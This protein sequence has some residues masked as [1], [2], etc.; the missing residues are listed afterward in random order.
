MLTPRCFFS[1]D[2][3]SFQDY[4]FSQPHRRRT[5]A[6]G[7]YLWRPERPFK[8]VHY[9]LSGVSQNYV[10]H[11]NGRRKIISFHG[12]G[13]LFPGYHRQD[14]KIER[15]LITRALSPMEVLEFSKEEFRL[16]FAH[17][18]DLSAAV[19]EWYAMYVNL[20]LYDT[21]HQ[22]YNSSFLKL[23]NLLYLLA[24]SPVGGRQGGAEPHPGRPG[25]PAGDQPGQPDPRP[26]PAAPPGDSAHP[27]GPGGAAGSAGPG[28][29]LLGGDPPLSVIVHKTGP[30]SASNDAHRRAAG[31]FL[32]GG[33]S[34]WYA[35]S[36]NLY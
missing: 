22:E 10:E 35:D 23:C 14:Y 8:S 31:I 9:I 21:A 28:P 1:E 5:F 36:D 24:D 17:N 19:V 7:D 15:S 33:P 3:R 26:D 13:T 27:A 25:R 11:E 6:R 2:F 12:P 34:F 29:V 4:F 16:M 20:L 32:D 30:P 18:G